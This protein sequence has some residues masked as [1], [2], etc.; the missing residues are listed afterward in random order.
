[1]SRSFTSS[2]TSRIQFNIGANTHNG[3][4]N[5]AA[6]VRRTTNSVLHVINY[7][8]TA[9][10]GGNRIQYACL[11]DNT[12]Q[13]REGNNVQ[14]MTGAPVV[15]DGWCLIGV[16]KDSAGTPRFHKYVFSTNTWSHVN[17]GGTLADGGAPATSC[18]IG[19][20]SS[21]GDAF[22]GDIA[23]VAHWSAP[24][25]TDAVYESF[26]GSLSAWYAPNNPTGV[27]ILDQESTAQNVPD[28][29]GRGANQSGITTTGMGIGDACPWSPGQGA[30]AA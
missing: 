29:T 25:F 20:W 24:A 18:Y 4:S 26:V 8:G 12:F 22:G 30:I 11:G 5:W 15:A 28:T 7:Y 21:G 16:G 13:L 9:T 10:S 2:G 3:Q 6:I 23:I 1:M 17:A 27:W 19:D 14:T